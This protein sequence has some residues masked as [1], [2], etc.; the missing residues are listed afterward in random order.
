ML[1]NKD[2]FLPVVYKRVGYSVDAVC[3]EG[4]HAVAQ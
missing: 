4:I 2:T 3:F 1:R